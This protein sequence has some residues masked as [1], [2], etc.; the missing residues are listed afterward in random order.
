[1]WRF[2]KVQRFESLIAIETCDNDRG[3]SAKNYPPVVQRDGSVRG[4]P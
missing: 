2:V 3:R 1:V 4:L